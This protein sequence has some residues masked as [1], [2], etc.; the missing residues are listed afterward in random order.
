MS[1]K[2]L[3]SERVAFFGGVY[4]NYLALEALLVDARTRGIQRLYCLGD[5][6]AFGPSPD[7][8]CDI[9]REA[10]IPVI[11]GNYDSSV[12]NGLADCQ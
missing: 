9:L 12:G 5:L 4:S 6:G 10:G 11:Q 7:R 2:L 1:Q 3:N 8:A